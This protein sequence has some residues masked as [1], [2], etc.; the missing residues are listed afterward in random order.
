MT[1]GN[2]GTLDMLNRGEIAMGPVWVDMFYTWQA[3]GKM[4]PKIKL[5]A[6]VA[7]PAGPADV[8][9]DPGQG[10]ATP[11]SRRSSSTSPR[12]PR[13]RPTASSSSST[14]IRASIRSTCRRSSTPADWNKL[15]TD[16]TPRGPREERPA[17]PAVGLLHRHRRRVRAR[18]AEVKRRAKRGRTARTTATR[19]TPRSARGEGGVRARRRDVSRH[20]ASRRLARLR[21][22]RAGARRHRGVLRA[23]ARAVRRPRVPRARTA[24]SRSSIS[25][26]PG[27]STGPTSCSRSASCCC[28]RC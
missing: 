6:A 20:D 7:R 19:C 8:L 10:R 5:V 21:A 22:R 11:R 9:R 26:R 23:A 12:A 2:A 28:R 24:A 17:V 3:D 4:N 27:T 25:R 14:G 1:P 18:R 16:I 13:S 15:F